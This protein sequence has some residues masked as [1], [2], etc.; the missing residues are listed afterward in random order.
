VFTG[1]LLSVKLGPGLLGTVLDGIGRPLEEIAGQNI[2]IPRG[3]QSE[4][5]P[6]DREWD[7]VPLVKSGEN[8]HG[9]TVVG[10]V[11]EGSYLKHLIMIPPE[12]GSLVVDHVSGEG[13][14]RAE[15]IVAVLS[16]GSEIRLSQKWEV[17]KSRPYY[18]RLHFD[19]PLIPPGNYC[20]SKN[21]NCNDYIYCNN[22]RLYWSR[23]LRGCH[24]AR[25]RLL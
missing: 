10:E 4:S 18:K 8:V 23:W 2:Y 14:Y 24:L 12:K 3:F 17:R 6:N 15:D 9:G 13:T 16:D 21:S 7:F 22:C 19:A 20:R 1:E 25:H 5:I 11:M